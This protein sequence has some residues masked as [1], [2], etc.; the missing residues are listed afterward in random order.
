[1]SE[2]FTKEGL[3]SFLIRFLFVVGFGLLGLLIGL[4]MTGGIK[5][6][7]V[8][9]SGDVASVVISLMCMAIGGFYGAIKT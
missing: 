4:L 5:G 6:L 9:G 1:M 3:M 2:P 7:F 8:P